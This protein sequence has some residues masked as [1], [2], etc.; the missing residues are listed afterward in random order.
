VRRG[1]DAGKSKM[2][3]ALGEVGKRTALHIHKRLF[4]GWMHDLKDKRTRIRSE[5]MEIVIVL[6]WER[7][8]LGGEA[9]EVTSDAGGVG[10][11]EGR[12][13]TGFGHHAGNCNGGES[14]RA[15]ARK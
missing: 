9:I 12:S 13:D 7:A 3:N 4:P 15:N 11:G 2:R 14:D 5:E 10:G 1:N 8:H 6:A